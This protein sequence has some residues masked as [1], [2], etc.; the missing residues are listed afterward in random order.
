MVHA[1]THDSAA[2]RFAG[3][4]LSAT[5]VFPASCV[6]RTLTRWTTALCGLNNQ[7]PDGPTE[8]RE[9][10]AEESAMAGQPGC[11]FCCGPMGNSLSV[12][13]E[14]LYRSAAAHTK[15]VAP[16]GWWYT[17]RAF[18][19]SPTRHTGRERRMECYRPLAE[20]ATVSACAPRNRG[21]P[22]FRLC[23]RCAR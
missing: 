4:I 5:R 12:L 10:S 1:H 3:P 6:H 15:S 19:P 22:E 23:L 20:D 8:P 13:A 16:E 18:R 9:G 2:R 21:P 14:P 7:E 17:P 11:Q